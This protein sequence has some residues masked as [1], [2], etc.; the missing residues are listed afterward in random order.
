M[1][2]VSVFA[3]SEG[4]AL[5]VSFLAKTK[6]PTQAMPSVVMSGMDFFMC[7][8]GVKKHVRRRHVLCGVCVTS[9][10]PGLHVVLVID[11]AVWSR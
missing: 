8:V 11:F 10:L 7:G 3:T 9:V 5:E 6:P 4:V 1:R 2:C